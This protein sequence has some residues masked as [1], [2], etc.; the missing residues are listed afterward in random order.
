M[1]SYSFT[2]ALRF[3]HPDLAPD[4]IPSELCIF[5]SHG[6]KAGESR[7]TPKGTPLH[8]IHRESYW[9]ADLVAEW[10]HSSATEPEALI[11]ELLN[12]L[13]PHATFVRHLIFSGGRGLIQLNSHSSENYAI[14]LPS[15][16][17][18]QCSLLGLSFAHD[19]YPTEQA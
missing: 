5:N 11:L 12:R 3:W 17:L 9:H 7:I 10:I 19:V 14:V 1:Q 2:L 6:W 18:S 16:L 4:E 15:E 13:A 8:G